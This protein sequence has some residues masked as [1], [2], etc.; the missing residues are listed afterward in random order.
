MNF[1]KTEFVRAVLCAMLIS[2]LFS[3]VLTYLGGPQNGK[4]VSI[5]A[6]LEEACQKFQKGRGHHL[7]FAGLW[8]AFYFCYMVDDYVHG[9][10]EKRKRTPTDLWFKCQI[11]HQA[12]TAGCQDVKGHVAVWARN[13]PYGEG[14]KTWCASSEK[15]HLQALVLAWFCFFAQVS[16]V[17]MIRI[18]AWFGIAGLGFS[19]VV[20]IAESCQG[21]KRCN[22]MLRRGLWL[23]E[24]IGLVVV[25]LPFA[26]G[27]VYSWK[28]VSGV[29]ILIALDKAVLCLIPLLCLL[30][31]A[32]GRCFM[33]LC[34]D[35]CQ[36]D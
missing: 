21:E 9:R 32:V 29:S 27:E 5:P 24:N 3:F 30:F 7:L 35:P 6:T 14:K 1:Q 12:G 33:F 11:R 26:K 16:T 31:R 13:H 17:A 36:G 15:L 25:M 4:W 34:N 10:E 18:S 2:M 20:V 22:A 8:M 28:W 23:L 19:C